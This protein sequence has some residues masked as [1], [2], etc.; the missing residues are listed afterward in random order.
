MGK[1]FDGILY[2]LLPCSH[3]LVWSATHSYPIVPVVTVAYGYNG[4]NTYHILIQL[5]TLQ[6]RRLAVDN[7]VNLFRGGYPSLHR[8]REPFARLIVRLLPMA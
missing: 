7:E 4:D 1:A 3:V 6:L 5:S 8:A 2:I